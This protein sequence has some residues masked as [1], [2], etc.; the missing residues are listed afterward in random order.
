MFLKC[1]HDVGGCEFIGKIG[2][3]L[4]RSMNSDQN[5]VGLASGQVTRARG[6][7]RLIEGKRWSRERRQRIKATPATEK[8]QALDAIVHFGVCEQLI[9]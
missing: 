9:S 4:G 3:F 1:F 2:V 8:A 5:F 7:V 6:M